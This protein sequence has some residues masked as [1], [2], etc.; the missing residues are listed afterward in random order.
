MHRINQGF[1]DGKNYSDLTSKLLYGGD[2]Y[3]LIADYRAYADC[4]R[5]LYERI[6][7]DG[8]LARL[9]VMNTAESG[10]FAADRA[11]AEYAHNIWNI[12]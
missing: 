3:M 5:K 12:K 7:D 8:E 11:I 6:K 9:S 2:E 10:V 1:A 4:Q